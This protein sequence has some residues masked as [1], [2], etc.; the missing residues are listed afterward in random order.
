[1]GYDAIV[2]GAGWGGLSAAALLGRAGCKV[3]ILEQ[4]SAV[5]GRARVM[6][7]AGFRLEYGLHGFRHGDQG[8]AVQV[9]RELG[10]S[11]Q[12]VSG[13]FRNYLARG[14]DLYPL[15]AAP[16][17]SGETAAFS[18][19]A[20]SR[21]G[22]VMEK[23]LQAEPKEWYGK[24][25]AEFLGEA[26]ADEE[27]KE[28]YL[29]LGFGVMEPDPEELS[30]GELI[31]FLK[32]AAAARGQVGDLVGGS[33]QLLD[34]LTEAVA[35][36]GGSI[37]LGSRVQQLAVSDGR[38][39]KVIAST[40]EFAAGV[41]VHAAPVQGLFELVDEHLFKP[42]FVRR[43]KNLVPTA[44]IALD[45]GLRRP[46]SEI[47]GWILDPVDRVL[48]RFP[49]N[50]DPSVAPGG[51]QLANFFMMLDPEACG[52]AALVRSRIHYLRSRVRKLFPDF[53]A[54]VEWE[55]I[56]FLP[57]VDGAAPRTRQSLLQRVD[58]SAPELQNLFLIGDTTAGEGV[59]GDI[60]FDSARQAAPRIVRFLGRAGAS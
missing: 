40:G 43:C 22:Q 44:G 16:A 46:V 31:A 36:A 52:D 56:L 11:L 25:F 24:S 12:F 48:G 45:Y 26:A 41:V 18:E 42:K 60:A 51:K 34:Q 59:S 17:S 30:A 50:A 57:V 38:I 58:F 29:L 37:F 47:Q 10:R 53:E 9:M 33:G 21:M 3:A 32:K 39:E 28:F 15:K 19:A 20:R 27:L 5:G 13:R 6:E 23:L 14:K 49:S 55:R 35:L 2:I 1:M 7:R 4:D 54:A 8:Y